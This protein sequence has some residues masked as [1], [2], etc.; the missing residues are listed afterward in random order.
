M[1]PPNKRD[2]NKA[3]PAEEETQA[4]Q[5]QGNPPTGANAA[6]EDAPPPPPQDTPVSKNKPPIDNTSSIEDTPPSSDMPSGQTSSPLEDR[7]LAA[8]V[9]TTPAAKKTPTPEKPQEPSAS[10]K[11]AQKAAEQAK[12]ATTD[13]LQAFKRLFTDPVGQLSLTHDSLGGQRA[14][15]VGAVFGV[16]AAFGMALAASV[17]IGTV[18][19]MMMGATGTTGIHFGVLVRAFIAYVF[20]IAAG[21]GAIYALAPVFKGRTSVSSSVYISGSTFLPLGVALFLAAIIA[22]ILNNRLGV[23]LVGLL[24]IVGL[25]FTVMVLN[26]GLRHIIGLTERRASLATPAVLAITGAVIIAIN[27]L[28]R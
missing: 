23:I 27:W 17:V 3:P 24:T 13:A 10:A 12:A 4:V 28:L 7:P 15:G 9:E 19:H 22:A 11:R 20:G 1:N 25:C 6:I 18:M 14:L 5:G 2:A 26:A 21:A 16:A 8:D